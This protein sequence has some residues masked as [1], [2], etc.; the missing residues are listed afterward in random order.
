VNL[1]CT[2]EGVF[3][4]YDFVVDSVLKVHLIQQIAARLTE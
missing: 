1:E 4:I 2:F 3:R